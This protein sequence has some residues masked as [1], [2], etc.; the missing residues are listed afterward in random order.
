[1]KTLQSRH[2]RRERSPVRPAFV[3]AVCFFRFGMKP[4]AGAEVSKQRAVRKIFVIFVL[5]DPKL[6]CWTAS[7]VLL[8]AR[9]ADITYE[10]ICR[11]VGL[12]GGPRLHSASNWM[13]EC[14]FSTST[15][16]AG[17]CMS[18]SQTHARTRLYR[19]IR[20]CREMP[21]ANRKRQ[22]TWVSTIATTANLVGS[23]SRLD[24]L[25]SCFESSSNTA[26]N[27]NIK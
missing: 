20:N 10:S 27:M 6:S 8:W 21:G 24:H 15:D 13:L 7:R 2:S 25:L 16:E 14:C 9:K 1:M 5:A 18:V 22:K 26:F 17:N 3:V 19:S 23:I 11:V 12:L 4:P